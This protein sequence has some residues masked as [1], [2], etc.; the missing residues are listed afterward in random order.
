MNLTETV[1]ASER[2]YEGRVVRLR[3]DTV[4]LPNGK[5][6]KREVVEHSGAIAVVPL[7]ANG[8]VLLVR[9][10][11]LPANGP[12]LE[13]PAGGIEEGEDPAVAAARELAE[14]I[15][16]TPGTLTPLY[17]AYVAPGYCTEK[18][19]G[20]L[21]EDLTPCLDAHT[22]HDEFVETV[23]LSLDDSLAAIGDGRIQDMKSI[24]CLTMAQRLLA[25]R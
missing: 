11:R 15:G 23:P 5:S 2:K 4:T 7:D 25:S 9:Q 19:W 13:V 17:E 18:I 8:N 20:Y 3:V 24:A 10:F 22:D 14:E 12:L 6:S 16:F 21:A 1:T